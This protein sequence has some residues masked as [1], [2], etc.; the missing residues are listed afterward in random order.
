[1]KNKIKAKIIDLHK[2]GIKLD[3]ALLV[4]EGEVKR[5]K[6]FDLPQNI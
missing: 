6:Y 5:S 2:S 4:L 3:F 1:M